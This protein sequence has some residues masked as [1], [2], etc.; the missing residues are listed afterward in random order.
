ME[1]L[2][3]VSTL[4]GTPCPEEPRFSSGFSLSQRAGRSVALGPALKGFEKS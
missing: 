1:A 3:L 2:R 4:I